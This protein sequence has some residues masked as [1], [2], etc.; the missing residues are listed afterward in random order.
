[1]YKQE[2]PRMCKPCQY[3]CENCHGPTSCECESC[4]AGMFF[5]N[6]VCMNPCDPYN[7][8]CLNMTYNSESNGYF[9]NISNQTCDPCHHDCKECVYPGH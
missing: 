4:K 6:H 7:N 1:M 2:S 5:L 9:A 8:S 3:P